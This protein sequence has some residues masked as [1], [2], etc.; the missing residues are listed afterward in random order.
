MKPSLHRARHRRRPAQV[1]YRFRGGWDVGMSKP[2][3]EPVPHRRHMGGCK[4]VTWSRRKESNLLTPF[5]PIVFAPPEQMPFDRISGE[6]AADR[7]LTGKWAA[8]WRC[9][10]ATRHAPAMLSTKQ[11]RVS[12]PCRFGVDATSDQR[13]ANK[14]GKRLGSSNAIS[15]LHA[16]PAKSFFHTPRTASLSQQP[17]K[18]CHDQDPLRHVRPVPPRLRC[19]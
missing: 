1:F 3:V 7:F 8:G 6:G 9:R 15:Q 10:R 4:R 18:R 13:G 17:R 12:A 5:S 16:R 2:N 11:P 19:R 14:Y